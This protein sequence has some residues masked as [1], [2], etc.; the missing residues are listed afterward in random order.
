MLITSKDNSKIKEARKLL[1]KKY[2]NSKKLFL[3]EGENL[4]LE[5]LKNNSLVDLFI[6]DGYN[7]NIDFPYINVSL[8]VMKT[9]S[10]LKSTP[11]LIGISRY[12]MNEKL[13]NKIVI[14]D[15]IQDP[16]NAG[17]IIRNSVAFGIDTIVFSKN[18][19]SPYNPKVLRSTGGMIFNIN[20]II[21]DLD[22]TIEMIKKNNITLIG[23]SL[24][25]S[26]DLN[27]INSKEKYAIVLGN[28]GNGVSDKVLSLCDE[29]VRIDM[30]K[31]C[32]SLNVGVASGIILYHM[33]K[34]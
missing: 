12:N 8:D 11:R 7:I 34:G 33:Y 20:I 1:D 10:D 30:E 29:I 18:S 16:G 21:D 24:K 5:S 26:K 19:V 22:K 14:L 25:K 27:E 31:E 3:I 32:E 23:T 4:V 6:L 28:E 9:L 13:G 2:S 17:T 15:D